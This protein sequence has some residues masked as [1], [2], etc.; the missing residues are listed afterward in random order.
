M[1]YPLFALFAAVSLSALA[2]FA[3]D[4]AP[5]SVTNFGTIK[6]QDKWRIGTIDSEGAPYCAMVSKYDKD[7]FLAFARDQDGYGSLALDTSSDLFTP[8]L[9][10]EVSLTPGSA[11]KGNYAGHAS[12]PRSVVIQIGKDDAF[13][14]AM[15][16]ADALHVSLP[17]ANVSFVLNN[18]NA[19][20]KDL[21]DCAGNIGAKKPEMAKIDPSQSPLTV[22]EEPKVEEKTKLASAEPA[23]KGSEPVAKPISNEDISWD[24]PAS[25]P[26]PQIAAAEPKAERKLLAST[27]AMREETKVSK[28]TADTPSARELEQ[29]QLAAIRQRPAETSSKSATASTPLLIESRAGDK[30]LSDT[31]ASSKKEEPKASKPFEIAKAPEPV[32]VAEAK[33]VESKP[34]DVPPPAPKAAE[35]KPDAKPAVSPEAAALEKER[36]SLKRQLDEA[37]AFNAMT[38]PQSKDLQQKLNQKE[39]DLVALEKRAKE[40]ENARLAEA[41]RAAKAQADLEKTR[42]ELDKA[43][44][45]PIL[46][47]VVADAPVSMPPV[48]P[49]EEVAKISALSMPA[50]PATPVA[51]ESIPDP[52]AQKASPAPVVAAVAPEPAKPNRAAAFLDRIMSYHRHGGATAAPAP[53]PQVAPAAPLAPPVVAVAAEPSEDEKA[54]Q[55]VL[56]AKPLVEP[57]KVDPVKVDPVKVAP[58]AALAVKPVAADKPAAAPV[59]EPVKTAAAPAAISTPP[60]MPA[61]VRADNVK[62]VAPTELS[63]PPVMDTAEK[64]P[65]VLPP[66]VRPPVVEPEPEV[67]DMIAKVAE[68]PLAKIAEKP[69]E[70][71]SRIL[72]GNAAKDAPKAEEPPI[73]VKPVAADLSV[74]P[75]MDPEVLPKITSDTTAKSSVPVMSAPPKV[76]D[77]KSPARVPLS[78][79]GPSP[80]D[81]PVPQVKEEA[82]SQIVT[83]APKPVAPPV[84]AAAPIPAP[85]PKPEPKP[86]VLTLE[87]LL[88]HSDVQNTKFVAVQAAP[89]EV[90]RQ[91]KSGSFTGLYE[92]TPEGAGNFNAAMQNYLDRYREDCPGHLQVTVGEART[93]RSGTV[94]PAAI[95]CN[96]ASNKYSTSFVFLQN[97][98][99]F[100][101]VAHTGQLGDTAAL[102]TVSDRIVSSLTD[103]Q[104][105]VAPEPTVKVE[106]PKPASVPVQATAPAPIPTSTPVS[107]PV[108]A[109]I[110]VPPPAAVSAPEILADPTPAR[111]MLNPPVAEVPQKK[112][113]FNLKDAKQPGNEFATVVIE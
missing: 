74:P 30:S 71:P 44:T 27:S 26:E 61:A 110:P 62:S 43:K 60:A 11:K 6:S 57:V 94:A 89:G 84:V 92:Q 19:S 9:D 102:K 24:A 23:P 98:G 72:S 112:L 29:K 52:V 77:D 83:E 105:F 12:S 15:S 70:P 50:V 63:K 101:A 45:T 69:P 55:Q 93:L 58:V 86:D 54:F 104:K 95:S 48:M 14:K 28:P 79:T 5:V 90:V 106:A 80:L 59:A 13:Y 68:Q 107:A 67:K 91:W 39:A 66:V 111:V 35:T 16:K 82:P 4:A 65:V 108:A 51:R 64:A 97:D 103:A 113:K 31:K 17:V 99:R 7:V 47:P 38:T 1:R 34:V 85:A 32:K 53:A 76:A 100:N 2:G 96:A 10:Y 78:V 40:A 73:A 49:K 42:A 8:D 75:A 56:D 20:Y 87:S 46:P 109:A 41:E 25:V 18:F 37:L 21:V 33:P 3:A 22:K 88:K 36:D 81:Q